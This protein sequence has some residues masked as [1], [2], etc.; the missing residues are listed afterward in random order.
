MTFIDSVVELVLQ[1]ITVDKGS[2]V[3]D[4]LLAAFIA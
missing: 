1:G 3:L 2:D 4:R